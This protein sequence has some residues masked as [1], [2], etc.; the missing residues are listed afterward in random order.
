MTK[1]TEDDG[2]DRGQR[3]VV[4]V[5]DAD[6][7]EHLRNAPGDA[8]A[9]AEIGIGAER[10]HD[11]AGVALHLL[12]RDFARHAGF[13][14]VL[15]GRMQHFRIEH[16]AVDQHLA[17]GELERLDAKLE[18]G[19]EFVD[20]AIGAPPHRPAHARHQDA[21]DQ[22]PSAASNVRMM[23]AHSGRVTCDPHVDPPLTDQDTI[24]ASPGRKRL[25]WRDAPVLNRRPGTK[26]SNAAHS[27][28]R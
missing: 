7:I 26:A 15:V 12:H 14:G 8:G 20:G 17:L 16:Q 1:M 19:V 2:I 10:R 24:E 18:T 5:A 13:P 3:L 4:A 21:V 9:D 22:R 28:A 25:C 11:L 23:T 27:C 6:A